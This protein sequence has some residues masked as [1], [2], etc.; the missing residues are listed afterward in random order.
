MN[1]VFLFTAKKL[2]KAWVDKAK[3]KSQWKAQK[4]KEGLGSL[5]ERQLPPHVHAHPQD[6]ARGAGKVDHSTGAN[7]ADDIS[8]EVAVEDEESY[9]SDDERT[10]RHEDDGA[11]AEMGQTKASGKSTNTNATKQPERERR[12]WRERVAA[13]DSKDGDDRTAQ[14]VADIEQP[15]LRDLTRQ[16]YSRASLHT[17]KSDPLKRRRGANTSAPTSV[18]GRGAERGRGKRGDTTE[19]RGGRGRAGGRDRGRG[20][21]AITGG[22]GG[23][24]GDGVTRGRGRGRD[25]EVGD[26]GGGQPNM[27]LRIDAM[28][29]KIKRD[30]T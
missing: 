26:G 29:E 12:A 8:G 20:G 11:F 6:A 1:R 9:S 14:A 19:I 7:V 23:G 16:A 15:S 2:K 27:K 22:R 21:G 10:P 4:R 25:V 17:F 3:I 24:R 13:P 5:P 28:L 18:R 30:Y